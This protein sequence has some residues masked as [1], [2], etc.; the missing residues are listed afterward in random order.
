MSLVGGSATD[1]CALINVF[2]VDVAVN[3]PVRMLTDVPGGR[4]LVDPVLDPNKRNAIIVVGGQSNSASCVHA[5]YTPTNPTK[6]DQLSIWTGNV[7]RAVDPML[8]DTTNP[9][10]DA[11][12]RF[13]QGSVFLRVA[14]GLITANLYDRVIL[15]PIG[16]GGASVAEWM[17]GGYLNHRVLATARRLQARS[18]TPTFLLWV[19]GATDQ[20]RGTSQADYLARSKALLTDFR[21][22]A[23]WNCPIF[24]G[25]DTILLGLPAYPPVRAALTELT[26]GRTG[27]GALVLGADHDSTWEANGFVLATTALGQSALGQCRENRYDTSHFNALGAAQAA[28]L[29]V[30]VLQNYIAAHP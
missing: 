29:W 7:Y 27:P 26:D 16:V 3:L 30:T 8:G 12:D 19:Q 13:N 24:Y 28:A 2:G 18:Y 11:T 5:T 1:P 15:V 22:T 14:D 20:A 25:L 4:T 9:S 10:L 6:I 23:G 21:A 17:P